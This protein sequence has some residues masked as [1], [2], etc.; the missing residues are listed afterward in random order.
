MIGIA[1]TLAILAAIVAMARK[2][3]LRRRAQ[4]RR[5]GS[6]IH[7]AI[8]VTGFDE[9][10]ATTQGLTCAWCDHRLVESGETSRTA[11]DRRF[12]IVRLV[13]GECEREVV[14]YFDV[15]Q[16]FH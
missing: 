15:T 16:V 4:Y 10:D 13:C 9:I 3:R 12:R 5:P 7:E 1:F 2:R 6:S 14:L 11:G 8:P